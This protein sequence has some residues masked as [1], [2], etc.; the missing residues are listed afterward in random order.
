MPESKSGALPLGDIPMSARPQPDTHDIITRI[1]PFC[2]SIFRRF[3][4]FYPQRSALFSIKQQTDPGDDVFAKKCHSFP[5]GIASVL[6]NR[7]RSFPLP[8]RYISSQQS[9]THWFILLRHR[10]CKHRKHTHVPEPRALQCRKQRKP[11]LLCRMCWRKYVLL[12]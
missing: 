8:V 10:Q 5:V 2:N 9:S 11:V 12:E 7:E 6:E 3:Q 1:F 4:V